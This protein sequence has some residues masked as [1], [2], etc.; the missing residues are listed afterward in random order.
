MSSTILFF[1]FI[2]L[3]AFILLAVNLIFAPHNPYKEKDSVFECGFHSFLGQNRTQFSISFFIFALL[4]LLFD[5]EIL[6]VYPYIV[7]AYTNGIYGLVIM[8]IFFIVLTLGFAFELGK[9]ALSID[10][11]QVSVV[12][13]NKQSS[14]INKIK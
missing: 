2:P 8:L 5:L 1:I 6:L 10:S 4:F 14:I 9:K 3:L 11:R 7:S 12:S 13:D